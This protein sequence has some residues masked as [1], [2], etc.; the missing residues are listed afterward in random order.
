MKLEKLHSGKYRYRKMIDGVK[1]SV[2]FDHKP[3]QAEI[4]IAMA[5]EIEKG[6]TKK[7]K[8]PKKDM[9]VQEA[10]E[11]YVEYKR[12]KLSPKTIREYTRLPNRLS[13]AFLSTLISKVDQ[14]CIDDEINA[15]RCRKKH[16]GDALA[17]KTINNYINQVSTVIKHYN[18]NADYNLEMLPDNKPLLDTDIYIPTR[19]EVNELLEYTS[20]HDPKY[21]IAFALAAKCGLRRS[22]I[23]ALT[24]EDI[25]DGN[26]YIK[27]A[28]VLDENNEYVTKGT[29]TAD[30]TRIVPIPEQ[31]EYRI[32]KMGYIYKGYPHSIGKAL[33]RIQDEMGMKRFSLHKLRHYYNTELWQAGIEN[34]ADILYLMG[35]SKSSEVNRTLYRHS[36][37]GQDIER[38]KKLAEQING[39]F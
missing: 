35:H 7:R 5:L 37:I 25:V 12:N 38:R 34:E 23:I 13:K 16:S 6:E 29:K 1:Y 21:Y 39:T 19:E 11:C 14:D 31:L 26:I 24:P 3:K 9:T 15:L 20:F 22:E 27:S 2:T 36:R 30:S 8:R 32:K 18:K 28:M 33:S 4:D 10:I 17:P